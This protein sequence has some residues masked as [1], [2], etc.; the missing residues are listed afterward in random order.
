MNSLRYVGMDVHRETILVA[1]LE[2]SGLV[3]LF[4]DNPR[5]PR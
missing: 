4:R 2:E 1:V 3:R 5:G